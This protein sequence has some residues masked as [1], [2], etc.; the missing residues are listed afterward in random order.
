MTKPAR[1]L[2][3]HALRSALLLTLAAC[4]PTPTG[5]APA[6]INDPAATLARL[7]SEPEGPGR[8][9]LFIALRRTPADAPLLPLWNLLAEK[10]LPEALTVGDLVAAVRGLG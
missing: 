7:A 1:H 6:D 9:P 8:K 2:A 4:N 5:P 3:A 10:N